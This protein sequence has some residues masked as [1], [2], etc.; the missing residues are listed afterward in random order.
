MPKPPVILVNGISATGKTTIATQLA[1]H[2]ALPYFSKDKIKETLFD[3]LGYS[4]YTWAHKLSGVTHKLLNPVLEELL[5]TNTGFI[6]EANFNPQFDAEK[7]QRWQKD[8]NAQL[9]QVLCHAEGETVW[10]R[11]KERVDSGQRHPGH[12]DHLNLETM[13]DYLL[14]GKAKPLPLDS[15]VIE[16][17]TTDFSKVDIPNLAKTIQDLLTP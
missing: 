12:N 4:D 11:F 15:P 3:E 5:K 9:I 7:Y 14:A 10:N 8:C 6:M 16:I 1:R 17:D 2:I 13:R